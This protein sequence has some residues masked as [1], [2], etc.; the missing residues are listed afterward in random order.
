MT[1]FSDYFFVRDITPG[2]GLLQMDKE[3]L[4]G[5]ATLRPELLSPRVGSSIYYY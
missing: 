1:R 2:V 4:H 3:R 5:W